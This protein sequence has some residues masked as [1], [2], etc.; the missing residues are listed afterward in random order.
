MKLERVAVRSLKGK[1]LA[2]SPTPVSNRD[3]SETKAGRRWGSGFYI[4]FLF[5]LVSLS[6]HPVANRSGLGAAPRRISSPSGS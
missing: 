5:F 1:D 4:L 6:E 3:K 2:S